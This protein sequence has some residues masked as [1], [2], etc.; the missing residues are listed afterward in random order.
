MKTTIFATIALTCG[1]SGLCFAQSTAP[2]NEGPV[3]ALSMIKTKTGLSDEYF[4][5]ITGTVKPAY[6][7]AKKQKLILDYKILNGEASDAHDFNIL[8]MVEYPNMA[9][10]DGLRDKMDPLVTKV[11]GSEDQRKDMAVKRLDIRE[12]LG[13]KTMREITLK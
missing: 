5:Q 2:Y 13:T 12:I 3:W 7:E 6:D 11:M 4:K 1:L 9:A 8:I 10:F